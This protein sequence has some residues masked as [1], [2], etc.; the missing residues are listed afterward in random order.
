MG[1][2]GGLFDGFRMIAHIFIGPIA[3]FAMKSEL[4][5]SLFMKPI[6]DSGR[7]NRK[8]ANN[9]INTDDS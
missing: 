3:A 6:A 1:D 5:T 9:F 8:K 4:L 7:I 2:V